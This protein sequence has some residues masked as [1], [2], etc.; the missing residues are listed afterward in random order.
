[1]VRVSPTLLLHIGFPKTGTTSLQMM[2][3]T[4]ANQFGQLGCDVL[5]AYSDHLGGHHGILKP[6][7]KCDRDAGGSNQARV[8]GRS[9]MSGVSFDTNLSYILASEDFS[10]MHPEELLKLSD[11]APN[12]QLRIV[13][14]VRPQVESIPR[15]WGTSVSHERWPGS[16]RQVY[17]GSAELFEY[18][19]VLE[20]FAYILGWEGISVVDFNAH[21]N[22]VD[23]QFRT[24]TDLLGV[25]IRNSAPPVL[26][27]SWPL[28]LL[29]IVR[30]FNREDSPIPLN[31]SEIAMRW[32]RDS[33][34]NTI[35]DALSVTDF[36]RVYQHFFDDNE[37]LRKR[38]GID[39][40]GASRSLFPGGSVEE[41]RGTEISFRD[42]L[43]FIEASRRVRMS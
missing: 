10:R 37:E 27:Q 15:V 8:F 40:N 26:N 7:L 35:L 34:Q 33:D 36:A 23:A 11:V 2:L 19:R 16:V 28:G 12:H 25:S 41:D 3:K 9:F 4:Y 30:S 31:W 29:R 22:P 13:A 14:C 32:P 20:S 17:E 1:M 18:H 21:E 6:L 42:I 24:V 39:L 43:D 38:F 5:S